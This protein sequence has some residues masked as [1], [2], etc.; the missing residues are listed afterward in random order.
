MGQLLEQIAMTDNLN[1][2]FFKV[3]ANRGAAGVDRISI[4]AFEKDLDRE[5][6]ALRRRLL[7]KERYQPPPVRRVEIEKPSGGSRSLGIVPTR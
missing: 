6:A 3:K 2:A 4:A 5:L 1:S 7:S